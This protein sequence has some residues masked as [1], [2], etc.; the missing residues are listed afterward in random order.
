MAWYD[1]QA[2][3]AGYNRYAEARLAAAEGRSLDE[4]LDLSSGDMSALGITG[5]YV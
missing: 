4:S 5:E 1:Q 3:T 2:L